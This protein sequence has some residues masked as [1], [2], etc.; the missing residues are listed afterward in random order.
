MRALPTSRGSIAVMKM[1]KFNVA[2]NLSFTLIIHNVG[3]VNFS[4][5]LEGVGR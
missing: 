5:K 2:V 3:T 4:I 1:S